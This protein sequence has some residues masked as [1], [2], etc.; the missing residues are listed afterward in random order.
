MVSDWQEVAANQEQ[1]QTM[2]RWLNKSTAVIKTKNDHFV[3]QMVKNGNSRF[4]W[5]I[6]KGI[7]G[8]PWVFKLLPEDELEQFIGSLTTMNHP[9]ALPQEEGGDMEEHA[10]IWRDFSAPLF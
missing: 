8:L 7:N 9:P 5:V 4:A 3:A 1:H 6:M 10:A 2:V